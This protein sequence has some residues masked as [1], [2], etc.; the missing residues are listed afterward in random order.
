MTL[1]LSVV[2]GTYQRL[3]LLKKMVQS[4]RASINPGLTY[5]IVLVGVQGDDDTLAWCKT[6]PDVRLIVQSGLQGAIHAFGEGGRAARGRYTV[7]ANDDLTFVG[8]SLTRALCFMQANPDV[9]IAA[10]WTDRL[11]GWQVAGMPALD[12]YGKP[13][14]LPYN[15]VSIFPTWLGKRLDHWS[16]PGARTYAGDNALVCRVVESGYRAVELPKDCGVQETIPHDELNRINNELPGPGKAHPDTAAYRRVYPHGPKVRKGRL[17]SPPDTFREPMRIVYAPIFEEGHTIQ[18]E[19]KYGLTRALQRIG[20]VCEVDYQADGPDSILRAAAD[21]RPQLLILQLHYPSPF[22]EAHMIRLRNLLPT[23]TIVNWS[24]DVYDMTRHPQHADAYVSMLRHV[25]LHTVVNE[26]AAL[27][28]IMRGVNCR[29]WQVGYEPEGVGYEPSVADPRYEV[30][31]LGNGYSTNRH[32]LGDFLKTLTCRVDVFGLWW[33]MLSAHPPT[34]Y[35][36]RAG[37]RLYRAARIALGDSEWAHTARGFVSNRAYQAMAAG[38]CLM[39]QQAFDGVELTGLV[40]GKHWVLWQ[41]HDDLRAKIDYYLDREAERARI[42]KAGHREVLLN[43]SFERRVDELLTM[44]RAPNYG[45]PTLRAE[46]TNGDPTL[47]RFHGARP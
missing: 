37:C 18:H 44:L 22:T 40:D 29:Y 30:L 38:G 23:A 1:D 36:F 8:A 6:Q 28:F 26:T 41:D 10:F 46:P 34:L 27:N 15:G 35:D 21:F 24:G 11:G 47:A 2:S 25:D 13:I 39:L 31:F 20:S 32:R 14:V 42:A 16:L 17:F 19:Q 5:E 9:G 4:A 45:M 33:P 12:P 43:H 3:S 7:F